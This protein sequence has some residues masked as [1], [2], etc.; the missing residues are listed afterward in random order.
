MAWVTGV[1]WLLVA[2]VGAVAAVA[3]GVAS[4]RLRVSFDDPYPP[5]ARGSVAAPRAGRGDGAAPIWRRLLP[6]CC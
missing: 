3:A 5:P 4:G 1:T 2:V 6:A